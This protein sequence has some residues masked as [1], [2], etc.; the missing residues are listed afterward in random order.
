[1]AYSVT[2]V[3]IFSY[4]LLAFSGMDLPD[5]ISSPVIGFKSIWGV[6]AVGSINRVLNSTITVYYFLRFLYIQK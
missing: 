5:R 2:Q 6:L 1:L 3:R 4:V